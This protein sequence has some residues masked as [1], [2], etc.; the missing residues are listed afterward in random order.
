MY[1]QAA[2]ELGWPGLEP[3]TNALKGRCSTIELPTHFSAFICQAL[4]STNPEGVRG[5][6]TIELSTHFSAF[7]YQ[8]LHSQPTPKAFGAALSIEL[9]TLTKKFVVHFG[10]CRKRSRRFLDRSWSHAYN[11]AVMTTE[12]SIACNLGA[13]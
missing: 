10:R 8:A 12:S 5:C 6:S 11:V 3:G 1:T 7:I 9:P 2:V 4:H 13:L